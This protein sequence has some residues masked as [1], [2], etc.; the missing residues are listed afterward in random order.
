MK[1][2][3]IINSKGEVSSTLTHST[4]QTQELAVLLSNI[5]QDVNSYMA[6][7]NK[8]QLRKTTLQLG[9]HHQVSI[10]VGS[11]QIKAVVKELS[12]TPV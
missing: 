9:N 4:E 1:G 5:L 2:E 11:D 3:V 12:A 8:L 6:Q 10:V 7:V